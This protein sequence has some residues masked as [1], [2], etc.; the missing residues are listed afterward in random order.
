[1]NVIRT[2]A[3]LAV[4]FVGG[5]VSIPAPGV[6]PLIEKAVGGTG[7]DKVL[8]IDISG[9][10]SD[11]E[12]RG[13]LGFQTAPRLT[14]R[15]REELDKASEDKRVKAVVLRIKTPGGEVT[16][17][18]IVHHEIKRF[19]EKSEVTVVAEL[20]GIATSGGYYIASA[21]DEIIAH[22]TTV[23]GA[24]GVVAYRINATGLMEKIGLTDETI[25]SGEKKDMG[26]PIRPMA[27]EERELLQAI[28]D[29]MFERFLD[30]VKEGRPGMDEAAL[31]EVSDGRVYTAEQALKLG[32]IDRIGY[33]ED[34]IE[35]AKER[36]G[37]EEARVV[38]YARPGDYRSNIYSSSKLAAPS[39]VNLI[40]IDADFLKGPGMRFMY[41]WMP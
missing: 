19:K 11:K 7:A 5:C 2:V 20:M 31:K 23:T 35:R 21:A 40:N 37:I 34:A 25:K 29:S 12:E 28:I 39:T 41:L 22:P 38:A 24:I 27:D 9:L 10:I 32:L 36:A 16:T 14:A 8:L 3:A 4:L 6:K 13:V 18:D 30:A 15:I 26:S 33:M 1:M 17:S